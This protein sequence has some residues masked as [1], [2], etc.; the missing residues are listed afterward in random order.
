MIDLMMITLAS[1]LLLVNHQAASGSIFI[2]G[3][4]YLDVDGI[5][6][7][8]WVEAQWDVWLDCPLLPA[9]GIDYFGKDVVTRM[10][11]LLLQLG[12]MMVANSRPAIVASETCLCVELLQDDVPSGVRCSLCGCFNWKEALWDVWLDCPLLPAS[13]SDI[14]SSDDVETTM[15]S[16]LLQHDNGDSVMVGGTHLKLESGSQSI[17][18]PTKMCVCLELLQDDAESSLSATLTTKFHHPRLT[19]M[20]CGCFNWKEALW[21][22]WLDCPLLPA[23]ESD[24]DSSD[25]VE[26]TI[27][28]SPLLRL[29]NQDSDYSQEVV[30]FYDAFAARDSVA[31]IYCLLLVCFI[32]WIRCR[33]SIRFL[34]AAIALM[35]A[36]QHPGHQQST[37]VPYFETQVCFCYELS[38]VFVPTTVAS[39]YSY[40]MRCCICFLRLWATEEWD[41]WIGCPLLPTS[42]DNYSQVVHLIPEFAARNSVARIC[43]ADSEDDLW[44]VDFP[45]LPATVIVPVNDAISGTTEDYYL[46]DSI[47]LLLFCILGVSFKL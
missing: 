10:S 2:G 15:M 30:Q 43:S 35:S 33:M 16:P 1:S 9:S 19:C 23:S 5:V 46:D 20:V 44:V 28:M 41:V 36:L 38:S 45:F 7:S 26:P 47:I 24:I 40:P 34:I 22:V 31:V 32:W 6:P 18:A 11:P 3:C 39:S 37:M 27:M 25:D 4:T 8:D 29:D 13:E 17:I 21:D 12:S 42:E 14:D